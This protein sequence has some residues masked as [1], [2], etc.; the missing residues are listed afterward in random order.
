MNGA[1]TRNAYR[2]T[3]THEMDDRHLLLRGGALDGQF[4]SGT[5]AV[6]KRVFCGTGDWSKEGLYLVTAEIVVGVEGTPRNVA[7]P[8]LAPD[9]PEQPS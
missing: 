2:T 7:I 8:A 4:W 3:A 5:V 6:G 9:R 1:W